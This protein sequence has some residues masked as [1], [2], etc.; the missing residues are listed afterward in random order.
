MAERKSLT[1]VVL[2]V[3]LV[4]AFRDGRCA[5]CER[6]LPKTRRSRPSPRCGVRLVENGRAMKFTHERAP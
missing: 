4:L 3:V 5:A 1:A 2:A 6:L